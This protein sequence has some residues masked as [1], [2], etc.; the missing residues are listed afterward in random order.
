MGKQKPPPPPNMRQERELRLALVCYGGVSLAVYMHGVT[1]EILKL[2]RASRAYHGVR[3]PVARA[4]ACYQDKMRDDGRK[5]D[6]E[7]VYFELLQAIG[8]TVD[9]RVLVDI[10]AG[11]SAGGINGVMLA[12]ALAHDLSLESHRKLWLDLADVTE[13]LDPAGRAGLW[14]KPYMRPLMSLVTWWQSRGEFARLG[15]EAAR[16]PEVRRKL[17]LF[18]R[19]RWFEP[20]FSGPRM[21]QMMLE[22]LDALG[23]PASPE[24]SLLPPGHMLELFVTATDFWG[25]RQAIT[26]HDPPMIQEREHRHILRFEYLRR[27]SGEEIS[28]FTPDHIPALAFAA[29]ATSCFPGAFPPATLAEID[30]EVARRG[31]RWETKDA[32]LKRNFAALY[33]AGEDPHAAAFI[34]GSVLMNKPFALAIRSVQGRAAH[35]EVDRRLVYID[36]N[37]DPGNGNRRRAD[38]DVPGFFATLKGALSD[39]PR[40]Q[41]IRDDLEWLERFNER[42]RR[43]RQVVETIKPKVV[44]EIGLLLSKSVRRPPKKEKLVALRGLANERAA[45][46]AAYA[47]DGYARLKVLG[48]L[49]D[50]A[51]YLRSLVAAPDRW[52][53]SA[54]VEAWARRNNIRP[55]GNAAHESQKGEQTQWV[56]FL[57]AFDVRFR[58]RRLRFMLRR[59]NEIY[60]MEGFS[61][62]ARGRAWLNELKAR[63]YDH[64]DRYQRATDWRLSPALKAFAGM[65]RADPDQALEADVVDQIMDIAAQAMNLAEI[66]DAADETLVEYARSCPDFDIWHDLI[67]AYLGFPYY[68]VLTLPMV[69]WRDLDE[70]DEIKVDRISAND[71]NTLRPG[72]ARRILKGIELANFGAFFSRAYRENDYLWGR[73][74]GAERL[75]DIVV[76]AAP[77]ALKNAGIDVLDIKKKLFAA[78]LA[79]E[80]PHLTAIKASIA[81]LQADTEKLGAGPKP[82]AGEEAALAAKS[83]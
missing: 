42:V 49:R 47:Y 8:A 31:A 30:A 29:R 20:P 11:A 46:Q 77:E 81:E 36:P 73:L 63:L 12:R 57:R 2:V 75:V 19:S 56:A 3:D 61:D 33:N 23:A 65:M 21:T 17:S 22:G 25:H 74:T 44:E 37:P 69:Q 78:I 51:D 27:P 53:T 55:I 26:L 32:F 10:V 71:A 13:L 5:V 15:G 14:S 41:P 62:T 52:G 4:A 6:S 54:H 83:G 80:A 35:R 58:V 43:L 7:P 38:S 16:N 67:T 70:L 45:Q 34:D 59:L 1:K 66:D 28:D 72:G 24:C 60:R 48:V 76:S 40:Y 64:L 82:Q 18:T 9:L 39:I 50:A 79:A 68:D